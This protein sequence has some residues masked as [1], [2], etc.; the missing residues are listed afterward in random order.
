MSTV[1]GDGIN[2]VATIEHLM[3][4]LCKDRSLNCVLRIRREYTFTLCAAA[5]YD[6]RQPPQVRGPSLAERASK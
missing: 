5:L 4:A 3:A 6:D 2:T 1:V